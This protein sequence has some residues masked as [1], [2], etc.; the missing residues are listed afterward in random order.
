MPVCQCAGTDLR[1]W[2]C[3]VA[4]S[5]IPYAAWCRF[6]CVASVEKEHCVQHMLH[7]VRG[8]H[9]VFFASRRQTG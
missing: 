1:A 9:A 5:M 4:V 2:T 6:A 3:Q 8:V 7:P